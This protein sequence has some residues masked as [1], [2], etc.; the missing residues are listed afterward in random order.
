M[1]DETSINTKQYSVFEKMRK[2]NNQGQE[3]WSSRQLARILGYLEYRNFVPVIDKAK[4]ACLN[5]K[6]RVE[7]H[8]VH[9]H[10]M[11]SI[12]SGAAREMP[13]LSLSRYA[14]YL[15]V[16]NADPSKTIVALGQ[17]YFAVQTRK[18]ELM[19]QAAYAELKSEDEKRLFLREELKVHNFKTMATRDYMV[20]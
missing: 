19:Q 3:Y 8:F 2:L 12:G 15:I 11:V 1:Q 13:A 6:Q 10:E 14:C 7:D 18:Q 4:V 5:S 9:I 17:T 20:V 16:Q